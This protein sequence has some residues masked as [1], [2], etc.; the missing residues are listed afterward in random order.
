MSTNR[1]KQSDF[2]AIKDQPAF[3]LAF[4]MKVKIY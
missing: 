4:C 1:G 2:V 3:K